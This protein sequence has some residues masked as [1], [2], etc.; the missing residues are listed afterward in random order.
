MVTTEEIIGNDKSF[1]DFLDGLPSTKDSKNKKGFCD[2]TGWNFTNLKWL[3]K[4]MMGHNGFVA[5]GC[6][7]NIFTEQRVKDIDMFFKNAVEFGV[8]SAYF[9]GNEG[10]TS[11]YNNEK[12]EAYKCKNSGIVIELIKAI[13]GTPEQVISQFDFTITKFAYYVET[14]MGV[15]GEDNGELKTSHRCLYHPQ[16]F[17]HL[18]MKRLVVD[19][20][21]PFPA[22]TY[23]R[24]FRYGKYG[25]FPCRETK[26]KIANAIQK[27]PEGLDLSASMYDGFD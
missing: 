16:F 19:D 4:H 24:F 20:Q 18:M 9:T 3:D 13:Y 26:L 14:D 27:L 1:E 22:S 10:Y 21:M 23:E 11:H 25:F 8:A 7:K 6:F 12:V 17:E 15:A 2:E 5:G